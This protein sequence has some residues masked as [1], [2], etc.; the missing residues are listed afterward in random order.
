LKI[1][2]RL[3]QKFNLKSLK[4]FLSH[5]LGGLYSRV[6]DNH[7][8]LMSSGLAFSLIVC[9]VPLVLI[10]FSIIGIMLEKPAI[11]TEIE[12][13][14]DR[15]VPYE[16][17]AIAVKE[18]VFERV[19]EFKVNKSLAGFLGLL[20]LLFASSRLFSSMRTILNMTYKVKPNGSI[21]LGIAGKLKD[22]GMVV[23]ILVYFLISTTVLPAVDIVGDLARGS[24]FFHSIGLGFLGAL[25]FQSFSFV[26]IFLAFFIVYYLVPQFKVPFKVVLV[27]ALSSAILWAT[28]QYLFGYYLT[29]FIT[30]KKVYGA[31]LFAIIVIF[32]IY[33]TSLVFILGAEIGQLYRERRENRLMVT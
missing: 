10:V 24:E 22:L 3:K 1:L 21:L 13:F 28:V 19:Q 6:G 2:S 30:L 18:I 29:H 14:I 5:Y 8:F 15:A 31:Y 32:W 23:L 26:L 33:Y 12:Y 16:K 17:G 7:D 25:T 11:K 4:S 27:S 9:I 20:G